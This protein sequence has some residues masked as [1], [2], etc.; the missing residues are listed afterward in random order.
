MSF[1]NY[2]PFNE[3]Y[4]KLGPDITDLILKMASFDFKN[5]KYCKGHDCEKLILKKG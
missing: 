5:Y 1:Y 3:I 2:Y 4:K